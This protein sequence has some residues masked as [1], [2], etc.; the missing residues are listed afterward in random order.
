MTITIGLGLW[1]APAALTLAAIAHMAIQRP[2]DRYDVVG[3]VFMFGW[4]VAVAVAW[5]VWGLSWLL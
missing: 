1:M 3:A 5:I 2:S 4:C